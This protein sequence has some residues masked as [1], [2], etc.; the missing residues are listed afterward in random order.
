MSEAVWYEFKKSRRTSSLNLILL[1][2]ALFSVFV[3]LGEYS[4]A[5]GEPV[6]QFVMHH[7]LTDLY[8]IVPFAVSYLVANLV[9][10]YDF[11]HKQDQFLFSS[12]I[13]RWKILLAKQVTILLLSLVAVII[14]FLF[15]VVGEAYYGTSTSIGVSVLYLAAAVIG[16]LSQSSLYGFIQTVARRKAMIGTTLPFIL[17]VGTGM[18]FITG[19][20]GG[21][22]LALIPP[23]NI[24]FLGV[25]I[26]SYFTT[27]NTEAT[28]QIGLGK[29]GASTL[30]FG[31]TIGGLVTVSLISNLLIFL[32]ATLATYIV[33][34]R[35]DIT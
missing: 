27:P 24:L 20:A 4:K 3:L 18:L 21:I 32:V 35:S 26:P 19:V 14:P 13:R 17:Y 34:K 30:D 29:A 11:T 15:G 31:V 8:V 25:F 22:T 16:I 23:I 10:Q 9:Y 7:T 5:L 33:F 1:V 28:M 6:L 2:S 12:P